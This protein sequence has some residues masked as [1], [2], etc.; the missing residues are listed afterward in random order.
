MDLRNR[1]LETQFY[2]ICGT[3]SF[4]LEFQT[5]PVQLYRELKSSKSHIV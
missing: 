1:R 3:T 5:F 2:R 4:F